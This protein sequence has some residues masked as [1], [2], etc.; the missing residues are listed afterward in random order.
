MPIT[1]ATVLAE[2]AAHHQSGLLEDAAAAYRRAITLIPNDPLVL[3]RL[4]R[5]LHESG[6]LVEAFNLLSKAVALAPDYTETQYLLGVVLFDLKRL[7]QAVKAFQQVITLDPDHAD[8]CHYLGLSF[9]RLGFREESLASFQLALKIDPSHL[10]AAWALALWLPQIYESKEEIDA[11]R[12]Q[13][14]YGLEDLTRW[15]SLDTQAAIDSAISAMGSSSITNFYLPYQGRNDLTQQKR[16]GALLHRV[17]AA[18]YPDVDRSLRAHPAGARRLRVGFVSAHFRF[19][20]VMKSHGRW[21]TDL[22]RKRFEVHVFHV[23]GISDDTGTTDAIRDS[24]DSYFCTTRT[25]LMV[26]AIEA[27]QLDALIYLDIGMDAR[28]YI[29]AALRLAPIQ[30]VSWGHP[31]TSGLPTM[32]YFLSS[33]LM[34]PP[35]GAAHYSETL[36]KLPNLGGSFPRPPVSMAEPCQKGHKPVYLC[37]Q[38][39]F[40]LLPQY[41]F[42]FP[43]IASRVGDSEFWFL[44]SA[45]KPVA[46]I[47]RERLIDAFGHYGMNAEQYCRIYPA[48]NYFDFLALNQ[49]ADIFLDSFL[50][51]GH[52][53]GLEALVCGLPIVTLP[54]PM[55]RGRHCFGIL[56]RLGITETIAKDV[57]DYCRIAARLGSDENFRR[58]MADVMSSRADQIFDDATPIQALGEFLESTCR[59]RLA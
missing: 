44:E 26:R 55:M 17:A 42:V 8:A 37:S 50:W 49:K 14:V 9:F 35:D 40:K 51:S 19:H 33:E 27:R 32:D 2:V 3:C 20:S 58:A 41:D 5:V 6:R 45:M 39:L 22:D 10:P 52:N 11:A 7:R 46:D 15:L 36:V 56:T 59:A 53:S 24:A 13:W 31:V 16:F 12:E 4:G 1:N 43:E 48:M 25:D 21:I 34:E 47:F 54:A 28:T 23:T 29:P 30:C 38:S 57:E 18:K